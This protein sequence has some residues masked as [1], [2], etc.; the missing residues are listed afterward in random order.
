[1]CLLLA[2]IPTDYTGEISTV[3]SICEAQKVIEKDTSFVSHSD[4]VVID[5][6]QRS[7]AIKTWRALL[8]KCPHSLAVI[9]A[10][11]YRTYHRPIVR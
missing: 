6:S 4:Q 10:V 9:I 5:T 3:L 1:M 11:K 2:L 7:A 8:D